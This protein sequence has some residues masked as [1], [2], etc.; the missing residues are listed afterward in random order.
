[1]A[2]VQLTRGN[3]VRLKPNP[4]GDILD[5]ALAGRIAAIE[6]IEQD[7]EGRIHV[8]VV[9]EDDPGRNMGRLRQPGRRFFFSPAELEPA[10]G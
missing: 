3:R 2:G 6:D 8:A 5:V 10:G 7:Y 1:V 4:G 9:V